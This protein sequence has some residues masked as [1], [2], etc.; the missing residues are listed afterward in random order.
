[1]TATRSV[2]G[3]LFLS[4]EM[5]AV[6]DDR[7]RL[8][9]MLDFEAALARAQA[10]YGLVPPEA[11]AAIT[12]ACGAGIYDLG[13]LGAATA[14]AGNPAIP[15]VKALTAEVA[16]RDAAAA[17][18]VHWG[19]TSQDAIDTG[20]V[21]Q[22]RRAHPLLDTDFDR[23][24]RALARLAERHTA[25]VMVGRTLLQQAV[26]ITFGL[27]AAGWLSATLR[28]RRR[29]AE[30]AERVRVLQFG[31]AAGSLSSLGDRGL[32]VAATLAREL[33]LDLPDLPWHAHRDRLVDLAGALGLVAGVLGKLGRDLSLLMQNEVAEVREPLEAGKGGSS[34]MAQKQNPVACTVALAA[35]TRVPGLVATLLAAMPQ[36]H[37][38]GLGGWH[39]EWET[40]PEVFGL[41]AGAARAM[42]ETFESLEIDAARMR[43]NLDRTGGLVMAEAV[44]LAL[45]ERIG[46]REAQA[47][48]EEAVHR[49]RATGQSFADVLKSDSK[50]TQ[51]IGPRDL[52]RLLDPEHHLGEAA[53]FV[54][55]VL[56]T[57]TKP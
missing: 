34:T 27:K 49:S 16:Q 26:P 24:E 4:A 18:F 44:V 21:L 5:A 14:K 10:A 45:A 46:R 8:Q 33:G 28:V 43:E 55:R 23:L 54:A 7:A 47:S 12:A 32:D 48:I 3:S 31:G 41:V 50:I 39:A 51:W 2:L 38:R 1:M 37:E 13:A 36:E 53:P 22:I 52:E 17:N 20:L 15:M 9:G 11:A 56:V 19:A 40:I 30:A 57:R 42:A 29:F 25:T 35:A 6:F